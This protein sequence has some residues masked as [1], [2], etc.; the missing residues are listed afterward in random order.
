MVVF[1]LQND[2]MK[3]D[4]ARELRAASQSG[5]IR[6]LDALA[7][8]KRPDGKVVSLGASDL[9][10]DERVAFGSIVG[11]LM[12]FGALGTV[13]GAE[14]GAEI[15]AMTFAQQN[16]GLSQDDIQGI[17]RN[18]PPGM[19]AVMVLFEHRW[20][21]PLKEALENAGGVVLAQG[22]VRPETLIRSGANLAASV[23]AADQIGTSHSDT[24]S[25]IQASC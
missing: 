25:D 17:A 14:A 22:M 3:G 12:G 19:T 18:I 2:R 13:E 16:F 21:V 11:A 1:G 6:V 23:R 20:A 15:G 9:S 5:A 4:V 7:I 10:P 24:S 8:L